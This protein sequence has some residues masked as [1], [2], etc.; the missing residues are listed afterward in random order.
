M[1]AYLDA[2]PLPPLFRL[3]LFFLQLNSVHGLFLDHLLPTLILLIFFLFYDYHFLIT[4]FTLL[5][6]ISQHHPG[7]KSGVLARMVNSNPA[8]RTLI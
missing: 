8:A 6:L 3:L 4:V 1:S 7:Q 2:A 5:L